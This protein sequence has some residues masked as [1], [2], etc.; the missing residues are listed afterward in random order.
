MPIRCIEQLTK[1]E[2]VELFKAFKTKA[3]IKGLTK[4][5]VVSI[6]FEHETDIDLSYMDSKDRAKT[7][8]QLENGRLSCVWVKVTA[9]FSNLAYYEG[10]DSLGQVFFSNRDELDSIVSDHGM[11]SNAI[12]DLVIQ[13]LQGKQNIDQFLRKGA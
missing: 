9:R 6:E 4:D 12:Q 3:E 5:V 10:L 8:R 13:V 2:I 1:G 7:M 11:T